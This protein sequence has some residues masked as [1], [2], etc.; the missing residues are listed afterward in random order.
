MHYSHTSC[1]ANVFVDWPRAPCVLVYSQES[2]AIDNNI[3]P[4]QY[5]T[6]ASVSFGKNPWVQIVHGCN[7]Y[8]RGVTGNHIVMKD[9]GTDIQGSEA[10]PST[11]YLDEHLMQLVQMWKP[12]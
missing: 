5:C 1:N 9:N 3:M 2:Y 4:T 6:I 8:E 10:N 7:T 11:Y 12:Y